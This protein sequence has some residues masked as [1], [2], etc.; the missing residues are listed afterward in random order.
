MQPPRQLS[1]HKVIRAEEKVI[2]KGRVRSSDSGQLMDLGRRSQEPD[3][4]LH[5]GGPKE[6]KCQ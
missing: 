5:H 1:K 3:Q 4:E 2:V 6:N